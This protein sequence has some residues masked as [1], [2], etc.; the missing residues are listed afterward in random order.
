M[1]TTRWLGIAV[2]VVAGLALAT[3]FK[4]KS[5]PALVA[6]S[7]EQALLGKTVASASKMPASVQAPEV[8]TAEAPAVIPATEAPTFA[9]SLPM[10]AVDAEMALATVNGSPLRLGD[11]MVIHA[12]GAPPSLRA[13]VFED[14]LNRAIGR[15]LTFQTAKA[16][17]IELDEAQ[18]QEVER[19]HAEALA[20]AKAPYTLPGYDAE[21]QA[22]FESR[23]RTAQ[24]LQNTM[25][26]KTGQPSQHIT[27]E[28][29]QFYYAEH[30]AEFEMLPEDPAKRDQ[31][32]LTIETEIR[33]RLVRAV[34]IQNEQQRRELLAEFQAAAVIETLVRP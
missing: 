26:G 21:A 19:I 32:W 6:A 12:A 1:N 9:S 15:E 18:K 25:L 10:V 13:D 8:Q 24:L 27:P 7:P 11:L 28:Q 2:V 20:R 3:V 16:R 33:D 4:F 30:Q 14:L 31:A 17:G 22:A 34:F 29:I 23:D 5:R